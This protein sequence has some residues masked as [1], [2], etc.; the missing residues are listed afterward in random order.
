MY[1]RSFFFGFFYVES[2][3]ELLS[4]ILNDL[5]YSFLEKKDFVSAEIFL[6]LALQLDL[7]FRG[8]NLF[9]ITGVSYGNL[10]LLKMEQNLY[11]EAENYLIKNYE[12]TKSIKGN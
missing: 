11:K 12:I 5:G 7:N 6:K 1:L 3:N 8:D 9:I 4:E 2:K 10:G